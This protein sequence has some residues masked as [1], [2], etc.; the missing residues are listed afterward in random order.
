MEQIRFTTHIGANHPDAVFF[1]L[2]QGARQVGYGDIGHGFRR[3]AG[4]FAYGGVQ[5]RAF[6]FGRDYGVHAHCVCRAQASAEIVRIGDAVQHQQECGFAQV[7]QHVFQV[8]MVFGCVNKTD[9]ALMARAF[10]DGVQAV[11]VGKMHAHA[12]GGCF[13]QHFVRARV[14]FVF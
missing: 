3:T 4:N 8:N 7:F 11:H 6:V 9:H 5:P 13:F 2:A 1:Q 10:G 14:V 12:L